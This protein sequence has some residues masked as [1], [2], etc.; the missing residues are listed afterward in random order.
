MTEGHMQIG[1]ISRPRFEFRTFGWE[2]GGAEQRMAN[3]SVPV[4]EQ[5][6]VR[7]SDEIYIM[8][9]TNDNNNTKIRDGKLDIKTHVQTVAGLEQWKPLLKNEFPMPVEFL[10]NEIFPAFRVSVPNFT[11]AGYNLDKFLEIV[12]EHPDLQAVR[13]NKERFAYMVNNTICEVGNI[14][15]DGTKVVTISSES[16][17]VDAVLKILSDVGL[18]KYEN[19]NYLQAIKRIIGMINKP[20]AS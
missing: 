15:I 17:E 14:L 7:Y 16:T 5:L 13:V 11:K 9:R 19:I 12:Q 20:L 8:S 4:P 18:K 10:K 1:E 3:L 6:R 2:F